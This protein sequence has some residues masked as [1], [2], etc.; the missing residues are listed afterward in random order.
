[1]PEVLPLFFHINTQTSPNP[2]L[3]DSD[4]ITPCIDIWEKL[5]FCTSDASFL[6]KLEIWLVTLTIIFGSLPLTNK[7][8]SWILY[9]CNWVCTG[10]YV[11]AQERRREERDKQEQATARET[12]REVKERLTGSMSTGVR[13]AWLHGAHYGLGGRN[14]CTGPR[15]A[16]KV[17]RCGRSRT[18]RVK[19][20]ELYPTRYL[21]SWHKV[22]TPA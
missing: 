8:I 14:K 12:G 1:M 6:S 3:S 5:F 18:Y 15:E 17:W 13:N 21:M 22:R 7:K 16:S 19:K 20:R 11:C 4:G 9:Q 10:V 2:P